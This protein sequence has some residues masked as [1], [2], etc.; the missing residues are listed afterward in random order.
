MLH[1]ELNL[2][3]YFFL[4]VFSEIKAIVDSFGTHLHIDLQQRAVEFGMLFGSH[5]HLRDALLEKMPPMQISRTA[6][7]NGNGLDDIEGNGIA[8]TNH[9]EKLTL[10][11]VNSNAVSYFRKK[12][13]KTFN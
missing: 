13:C 6:Q 10:P 2:Y 5:N 3:L 11:S 9:K 4:L 1:Y 7:F 12:N 8:I